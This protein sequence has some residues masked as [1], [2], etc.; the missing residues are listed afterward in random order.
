MKL[1]GYD[2][3]EVSNFAL[4]ED[5]QSQHNHVYWKGNANFM[6]FGMGASNL[7][8]LIRKTRPKTLKKYFDY[9][10]TGEGCLIENEADI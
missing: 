3:Y 9:V 4:R 1:N 10:R 8:N 5:L 2:Q 7:H 6:A